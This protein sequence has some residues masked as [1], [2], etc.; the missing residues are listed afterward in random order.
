M[1]QVSAIRIKNLRSLKD[2]GFVE[3]K[4]ITILVGKNSAGKSTFARTFPLLRQSVEENKR[5]PILWY[6]RLVDFGAFP[7]ALSKNA[8]QEEIEFS[9]RLPISKNYSPLDDNSSRFLHFRTDV[10]L[11][12][13]TETEISM[14]IRKDS[15][16]QGT[17]ASN[18]TVNLFG[19]ICSIDF[20]DSI[21]VTRISVNDFVWEEK[22]ERKYYA[23]Q[24]RLIP[25]LEF[26]R[27]KRVKPSGSDEMVWVENENPLLAKLKFELNK[28]LHGNTS[29]EKIERMVD[30]FPLGSEENM[31]RAMA[32]IPDGPATWRHSMEGMNQNSP[33]FKQT[34]NLIFAINLPS[35]LGSFDEELARYFSGIRYL[36]PLRASAQRYY[37]RQELAIDE[38]DSKGANVAMFLDSLSGSEKRAFEEWTQEHFGVIISTANEGGHI[39]LKLKEANGT[40]A[41]NLADM[42]FGFSQVL[43][44]AVQLW[45]SMISEQGR[46]RFRRRTGITTCLVIEQPE[47]HLHPEYQARLADIIAAAMFDQQGGRMGKLSVVA[48]THSPNLINRLGQLIEKGKLN[49]EDVQVVVFDKPKADSVTHVT[50]SNFDEKGF[51]QNWPYGF[52]EPEGY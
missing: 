29:A 25:K 48:E 5:A 31:L 51:L 39:A 6:G 15:S 50:I 45:S 9:F 12:E 23:Q 2:T 27:Q 13:D 11:L 19:N 43:P 38:I 16:G 49:K 17:Y 41:T 33:W 40:S 4:P 1:A 18:V 47:L 34:R 20:S 36:E 26:V 44:I 42:G 7:D 22:N 52:F 14:R 35:I 46:P 3:L 32:A 37:R 30:Q 21:T 10:A 24:R 8:E 28:Y